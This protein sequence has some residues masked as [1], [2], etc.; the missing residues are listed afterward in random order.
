[1][2]S[3]RFFTVLTALT[4]AISMTACYSDGDSASRE[5]IRLVNATGPAATYGVYQTSPATGWTNVNAVAV[6]PAGIT[7]SGD[8]TRLKIDSDGKITKATG[9]T[10]LFGFETDT[11]LNEV[12]FGISD[13][14]WANSKAKYYQHTNRVRFKSDD[15]DPSS[16][17]NDL[18]T[19]YIK[20][21]D[22]LALGGSKAGLRYGEFGYWATAYRLDTGNENN[23]TLIG[24]TNTTLNFYNPGDITDITTAANQALGTRN[25]RGAIVGTYSKPESGSTV[26]TKDIYGNA[27][28]RVD[29]GAGE[30]YGKFETW[31]TDGNTEDR[32]Y[33]INIGY[34]AGA[35]DSDPTVGSGLKLSS[36]PGTI[37]QF[38]GT[39]ASI[40]LDGTAAG[41]T[42]DT[43][44]PGF[45][46]SGAML[47]PNAEEMVGMINFET[48]AGGH[49]VN[50]SFGAKR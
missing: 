25:Y 1:M 15:V 30:I 22:T 14:R 26:E 47:G 39:G 45:D 28:L 21:I 29:F 23:S 46:V 42:N 8:A 20:Y 38:D 3:S 12:E 5:I 19:G 43:A 7:V 34:S 36:T 41:L 10:N 49:Q 13:M 50:A 16:P 33:D 18:S 11:A 40:V 35:A 44:K 17:L 31:A 37:G 4:F 27:K 2:K 24:F 9:G 48:S 32:W 6:D